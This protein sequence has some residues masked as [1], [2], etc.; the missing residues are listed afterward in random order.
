MLHVADVFQDHP[1]V[2]IELRDK[3]GQPQIP[4]GGA[5]PLHQTGCRGLELGMLSRE[6]Q[7]GPERL[8]PLHEQR[9]T[10]LEMVTVL[11]SPGLLLLGTR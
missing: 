10:P 9:A 8:Q 2:A 6:P 7:G 5:Q 1:G 11:C 3:L 4:L